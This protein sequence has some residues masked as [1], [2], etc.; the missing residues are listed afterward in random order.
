MLVLTP[1]IDCDVF[2]YG[3]IVVIA[4]QGRGPMPVAKSIV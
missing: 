4:L 3:M 1:H 2:L